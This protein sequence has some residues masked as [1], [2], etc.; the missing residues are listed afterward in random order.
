MSSTFVPHFTISDSYY[1]S[2]IERLCCAI[3]KKR[4]GKVMLFV[5]GNASVHKCDIVQAVIRKG[6]FVELNHRVYSP[7]IAP[8]D[9][10]LFSN[11]DQFLPGKNFSRGEETI[12]T[13]ENYLD[14]LD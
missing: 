1:V 11:L 12:D 3:L 10:Y 2:I 14:K 6:S 4:R 7:D 8:S 5:D 9:Y 13:V